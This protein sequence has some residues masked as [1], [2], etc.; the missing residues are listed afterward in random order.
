MPIRLGMIDRTV[1]A[2]VLDWDGT[3]AAVQR[4]SAARVRRRVLA[5]TAPSGNETG[6][7]LQVR[8]SAGHVVAGREG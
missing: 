2:V 7:G 5:L 3:A 8:D 4:A 6:I 1:E